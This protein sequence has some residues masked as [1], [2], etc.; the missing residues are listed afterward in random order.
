MWSSMSQP[1]SKGI[2]SS[3]EWTDIG[4]QECHG[5]GLHKLLVH[6]AVSRK[7]GAKTHLPGAREPISR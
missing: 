7:L 6:K 2:E 1:E 3:A 5:H 4:S